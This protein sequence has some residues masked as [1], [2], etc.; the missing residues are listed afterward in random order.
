VRTAR[1]RYTWWRPD[2]AE[3]Y[4]H[5]TDPQEHRNLARDPRHRTTVAQLRRLIED[6]AGEKLA[7]LAPLP[8]AAQ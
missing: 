5:E 4:D 2:A 3:L 1:Y 8:A 7:L 6:A